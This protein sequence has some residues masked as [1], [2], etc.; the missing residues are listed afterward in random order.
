MRR[1]LLSSSLRHGSP[2]LLACLLPALA[3]AQDARPPRAVPVDESA[4]AARPPRAVPVEDE[5]KP[6]T[7]GPA[8]APAPPRAIPVPENDPGEAPAKPAA[9]S[10]PA[11]VDAWLTAAARAKSLIGERK[12][13][14]PLAI[15][16]T[17]IDELR[18]GVFAK[19]EIEAGQPI[20]DNQVID[21]AEAMNEL[22]AYV[23]KCW[24][25][26]QVNSSI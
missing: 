1:T 25:K 13:G 22:D 4:N 19:T 18:R 12:R 9:V 7:R 15:E 17:S 2:L 14:T 20:T 11:Q 24:N 10:T 21:Q 8:P 26:W 16:R 3:H 6:A 5:A 23:S